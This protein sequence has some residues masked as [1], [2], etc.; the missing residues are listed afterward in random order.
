ML[1]LIMEKEAREKFEKIQATKKISSGP[2][3]KGLLQKKTSQISS[4][5]KSLQRK[6]DEGA[7]KLSEP[8]QLLGALSRLEAA[9]DGGE[10]A[11]PAAPKTPPQKPL[12]SST[13]KE[14]SPE[15]AALIQQALATQ[16]IFLAAVIKSLS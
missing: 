9:L 5:E 14:I 3:Q 6:L 7:A 12:L 16:A 2:D 11:Q 4:P 15:R 10:L 13:G 8:D 1:S